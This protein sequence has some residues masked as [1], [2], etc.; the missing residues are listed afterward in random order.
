MALTPGTRCG[1]YEIQS[2]I[3]EGGM[4]RVYRAHDTKLKRDVALKTLPEEFAGNVERLTRFQRE[5]EALAALNHPHIAGIHDIAEA[6]G[7]RFLVL[8]LVEGE[9]LADRLR[10]GPLSIDEALTIATEISEALQAAHERGIVHRDLKPAN[11]KITADGR[12]KVL[13]FGLAKLS[14]PSPIGSGLS[15]SPTVIDGTVMGA[16]LGTAAYMSPEQAAGKLTDRKSDVWAFGCVL[17]EMLAGQPVFRGDSI[18]E[19]LGG[20]FKQEPDWT[21]LPADTPA[22]IRRLLRRCLQ[23]DPARRLHDIADARI[24]IEEAAAEPTADIETARRTPARWVPWAALTAVAVAAGVIAAMSLVLARR[25][26]EAPPEMRVEINTPPTPDALAIAI[27]PDGEKL[28]YAVGAL[29]GP[30]RLWLRRLAGPVATPVVGTEAAQRAFWSPDS[31]SLGFFAD[32]RLK[33]IDIAGGSPRILANAPFGYGGT[34]NK[35]GIILFSGN[36]TGPIVRVPASGGGEPIAVTRVES[37]GTSHRLPRF[38]PDGR[39][40]LFFALNGARDRAI[41]FGSLDGIAARRL[42]EADTAP[43]LSSGHLLFVRQGVLL[44]QRFDAEQ[45]LLSGEPFRVAEQVA[46][47]VSVSTAALSASESGTIA[48]RPGLTAGHRQLL[49]F[50]RAGRRSGA[51][52]TIDPNT[53]ATPAL[54]PNGQVVAV[55]RRAN[56]NRDVWLIDVARGL[57]TRFTFDAAED[58]S[59]EWSPDGQYIFFCSNRQ[60]AYDLYRKSM[61]TDAREELLYRST[62]NKVPMDVSPDGRF[63]LYRDNNPDSSF[64]LWALPIEGPRMPV[65]VANTSFNEAEGQFSPD[66]KWIAYRSNESGQFEVY[67]QPFPGPGNKLLVSS[68]GGAQPRWRRDGA[69]LFYIAMDGRLMAVQL[70]RPASGGTFEVGTPVPLFPTRIPGGAVQGVYKQQY[71]VSADGRFLINTLID[72]DKTSPISLILNWKPAPPR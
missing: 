2:L 53:L 35:D 55:E 4:G 67:V 63:L 27:S 13:D 29:P 48:Y 61:S 23:K 24:E 1:P 26:A 66:G 6:D 50:D 44:A 43:V 70:R 15:H 51:A 17:Y 41:Y 62:H 40:F 31:R 28:V 46:A 25:P 37:P 7:T 30:A 59:P 54:S 18:G 58:A 8:E 11:I 33:R 60:G 10:H 56:D 16:I 39:H 47:D 36:V 64:D 42:T 45:G 38:L 20:I 3:G 9:T 65:A 14:E 72:E 34:W 32:G 52:G 19:V 49:W 71:A 68:N 5:A 21:R 57:L 22:G 12:V 69:E